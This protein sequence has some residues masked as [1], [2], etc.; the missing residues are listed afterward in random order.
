VIGTSLE[1]RVL[2][3]CVRYKP[4]ATTL[5]SFSIKNYIIFILKYLLF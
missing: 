2:L 3:K 1:L 5:A 4:A